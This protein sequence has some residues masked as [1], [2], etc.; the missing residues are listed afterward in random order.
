MWV[1]S[2]IRCGLTLMREDVFNRSERDHDESKS[3]VGGV[4]AVGP[5]DDEADPPIQSLVSGVV[6]SESHRRQ[7]ALAPFANG[8]GQ[9]DEGLHP[10]ALCSRTEP[11]EQHGDLV[12]CEVA[13]QAGP[14]CLLQGV[15]PP[16][17][18][19]LRF[20]L[21]S[22]A[23]WSSF[24]SPGTFNSTQRAPLNRRAASW[25]GSFRRSCQA[26]RRTFSRAWVPAWTT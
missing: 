15:G 8:L 26:W 13:G 17:V 25:S 23:D 19:P 3:G 5:I 21:R 18:G 11:V 2:G 9:A 1:D 22:V 6:H 12:F 4:E 10:A 16:E 7:D 24:R 20:S 14:Q